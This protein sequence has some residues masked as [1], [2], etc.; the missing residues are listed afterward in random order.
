MWQREQKSSS[1]DP[2]PE[3]VWV[4]VPRLNVDVQSPLAN[5][6]IDER[7]VPSGGLGMSQLPSV[8]VRRAMSRKAP[9]QPGSRQALERVKAGEDPARV[10]AGW[11]ADE[12]R[13]RLMRAKYLLYR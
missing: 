13:W 6:L 9:R 12:A 7:A 10:A 4:V 2:E 1:S 5:G 8:A 3:V 11:S